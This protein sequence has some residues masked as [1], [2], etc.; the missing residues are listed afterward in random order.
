MQNKLF[1]ISVASTFFWSALA[2][3]LPHHPVTWVKNLTHPLDQLQ[4]AGC[5]VVVRGVLKCVGAEEG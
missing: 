2:Q 5:G 3:T 4:F 1:P